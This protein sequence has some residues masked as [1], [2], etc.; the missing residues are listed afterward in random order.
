MYIYIYVYCV[1]I[2]DSQQHSKNSSSR[3]PCLILSQPSPWW[4]CCLISLC[5]PNSP[6]IRFLRLKMTKFVYLKLLIA[7]ENLFLL[8]Y[9]TVFWRIKP[10][11]ICLLVQP[12]CFH[13]SHVSCWSN[14]YVFWQNLHALL[15]KSPPF[16][17]KTTIFPDP[18]KT[19]SFPS[20]TTIFAR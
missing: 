15:H 1:E 12:S 9:I 17:S 3:N 4:L 19:T 13:L 11:I 10:A 8:P 5:G 6:G 20:K 2:M 16:P 14:L 7:K 18:R